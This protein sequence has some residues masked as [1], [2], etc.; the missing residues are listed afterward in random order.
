MHAH[1][2]GPEAVTNSEFLR[3]L[4]VAAPPGSVLWVD[5]FIGSPD[6]TYNA[7]WR[8]RPYSP[9][10]PGEIDRLDH[11]NTYFSVAAVRPDAQGEIHR[12]KANFARLVALVCDDV[13]VD[14]LTG[15]PSYVLATS[16]GKTQVGVLLDESDPDCAD[17][18]LV[19]RLMH[20]LADK[21]LVRVDQFGNNIVRYVRLPRGQNQK[22][23]PSGHF[24]H[25]LQLWSPSVRLTLE[26]AAAVFGVDLEACRKAPVKA[27]GVQAEEQDEKVR[28]ATAA[29]LRGEGLHDNLN[30]LAASFVASG[31][32]GGAAVNTL[33]AMM[34]S[35]A[36]PRDERWR[37]RY[38]DIPRA[39]SSAQ[40]KFRKPVEI[41]LFAEEQLPAIV[42]APDVPA[43]LLTVPGRLGEAV[44]WINATARKPQPMLA[45]QAALALGS[46]V[47]G[48]R[49]CT[50]NGNWPMLY[51][52]NVAAS[53][54]GKEH[55]KYA[56][57]HLLEAAGLGRLIGAG[58]FASESGVLS[59]LIERPAN[60][61]VIDEFGKM[62]QAAAVAQNF[63]DRNT[64]K[65]IT[66]VWGRADGVVRPVAYS[67]AGM[68]SRQAE[69][70]A[71]RLVR[72]PSLTLLAMTAHEP[73]FAGVTSASIADGFL[74]RF[75]VVYADR[76]RQ[77]ARIVESHE[78][79]ETLVEWISRAH[80][81][82]ERAGNMAGIPAAHDVEP[83][84]FVLDFDAGARARF[85]ELGRRMKT[86]GDELDA[87]GL[88]EMADRVTEMA[89]RVALVVAISLED[90]I[91]GGR[92]AAWACEYVEFHFLRN[93][94]MLRE[95]LADGPFDQLCKDIVRLTRAAGLRGMTER[96]LNKSSRTFRASAERMRLDALASLQ[97]RE[98]LALA[99]IATPGG[100]GR[101]R[102]A[103]VCA[104]LLK[105]ADNADK[106]PTGA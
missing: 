9:D 94:S 68:S 22:Q 103:Y 104:D 98:E 27:E 95:R 28:L 54:S 7:R 48:R 59:A 71:K 78:A 74:A 85:A 56:V 12:R 10:E 70:L 58:R 87:E 36:A 13:T 25:E 69:D 50:T 77:E 80:V 17:V 60:F 20:A 97:R 19:D 88:G 52:L 21:G 105:N 43:H 96:D 76:G 99:D 86:L 84:P 65:F 66:E 75:L 23:R 11:Y 62:M 49:Y 79:P 6:G 64:L 40:E 29:V 82:P 39:V 61:S 26:D 15:A 37:A 63:A 18:G 41:R 16:P 73:L 67:T 91:V 93:I 102:R 31:M 92:A 8:G 2:L 35:S 90:D 4:A 55:A 100:R 45:V 51:L 34:E 83:V 53:G 24:S 101:K 81:G 5:A 106:S 72:K 47:T 1:Q 44:M 57:E 32:A 38:E 33:R 3:E 14:D 89:M 30:I 46:T 42:R